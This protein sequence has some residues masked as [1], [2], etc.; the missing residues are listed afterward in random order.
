MCGKGWFVV[1]RMI[2]F[3]GMKTRERGISMNSLN[4]SLAAQRH[5]A[6]M[7]FAQQRWDAAL[8]SLNIILEQNPDDADSRYRRGFCYLQLSAGQAAFDDFGKALSLAPNHPWAAQARNGRGYYCQIRQDWRGAV[9]EYTAATLLSPAPE[10]RL[11]RGACLIK[12]DQCEQAIPDFLS[13]I[14]RGCLL[15]EAWYYL[16]ECYYGIG[17]WPEAIAAFDQDIRID[18]HSAMALALRGDCHIR[19]DN[20]AQAM[21]DLTEAIRLMLASRQDQAGEQEADDRL[22]YAYTTRGQCRL[23]QGDTAQDD[24]AQNNLAEALADLDQ[25]VRFNPKNAQAFTF[26]GGYY[27]QKEDWDKALI[28][29]NRAIQINPNSVMALTWRGEVYL[30]KSEADSKQADLAIADLSAAIALE[31]GEVAPYLYRARTNIG[32]KEWQAALEDYVKAVDMGWQLTKVQ[33]YHCALCYAY[34]GRYEESIRH[35]EASIQLG[36]ETPILAEALLLLGHSYFNQGKY[37]QSVAKLAESMRLFE[38]DPECRP[39]NYNYYGQ[40]LYHDGKYQ[41]AISAFN[42]VINSALVCADSYCWRGRCLIHFEA[43]WLDALEDFDTAIRLAPE[44]AMFYAERGHCH[45]LLKDETASRIDLDRAIELDDKLVLAYTSRA[46]ISMRQENWWG[47]L[48]DLNTLLQDFPPD[49]P[50]LP[51]Q[52]DIYDDRAQCYDELGE[53]Q[54]AQSDREYAE[55]LRQQQQKPS[56]GVDT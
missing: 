16:G 15:D 34:L 29:F 38:A 40:A 12:L 49:E 28:D 25:A 2:E 41:E 23:L 22:S 27:L 45:L 55:R 56:G 54:E 7:H 14:K 30:N 43:Q 53:H 51:H 19:T 31:P 37:A 35:A 24:T 13:L 32:K 36:L 52:A 5:L 26:R 46:V 47:A 21:L 39:F 17:N 8:E 33:L 1:Y 18:P 20:L 6:I 42:K 50:G 4:D 48:A 11:A 44:R 9:Q 10:Y 3:A